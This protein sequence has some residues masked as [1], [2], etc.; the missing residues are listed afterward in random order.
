[1]VGVGENE[2]AVEIFDL[3]GQD[4]LERAL[5]AHGHELRCVEFGVGQLESTAARLALA[6]LVQHLEFQRVVVDWE[7]TLL[8]YDVL[9]LLFWHL[10]LVRACL[11]VLDKDSFD[12]IV[13]NVFQ[14]LIYFNFNFYLFIV[15]SFFEIIANL[16]SI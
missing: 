9:G 7:L 3:L 4:T 11:V 15:G 2:I 5:R 6:A 16:L 8:L 13:K 1:M 14:K 12:E 10:Y